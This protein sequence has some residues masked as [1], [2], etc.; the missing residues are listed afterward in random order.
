MNKMK[1]TKAIILTALVVIGT[2]FTSCSKDDNEI[3]SIVGSW[4]ITSNI[5]EQF[6]DGVSQGIES[7]SIDANNY[8][9]VTFKNDGTFSYFEV[10][11]NDG[12]ST[13]P[14]TF[15]IKDNVLY[16][17]YDGETDIDSSPFTLTNDTLVL[18][19]IE[20]FTSG[21]IAFKYL[22]NITLSRQ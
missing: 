20:E 6:K 11:S 13:D 8:S 9:I 4:K 16:I 7:N 19:F 2:L 21:G 22:I 17:K 15:T 18:T 14:G 5:S 10:S 3:P 12:S 1:T